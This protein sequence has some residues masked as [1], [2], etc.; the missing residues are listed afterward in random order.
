MQRM[1]EAGLQL[2]ER[3]LQRF[4]DRTP[5]LIFAQQAG[6]IIYTNAAFVRAMRGGDAKS[7]IGRQVTS[8]IAIPDRERV[9]AQLREPDPEITRAPS[10]VRCLRDDGTECILEYSAMRAGDPLQ[11][12]SIITSRDVTHAR[13]LAAEL[14]RAD[15]GFRSLFHDAPIGIAQID[16]D[17]RYQQVNRSFCELTGY[18]AD[19]LRTISYF[20]LVVPEDRAL[21]MAAVQGLQEGKRKVKL[22]KRWRR[23]DGQVIHVSMHV[24]VMT[25][26]AGATIGYLTHAADVTAELKGQEKLRLAEEQFRTIFNSAAI[27]M[28]IT[29]LRGEGHGYFQRVNQ[30]MC[31]L[32]GYTQEELLAL[33]MV[34]FRDP[35]DTASDVMRLDPDTLNVGEQ[36]R[37]VKRFR[38]KD[39][40]LIEA[41]RY[42][43]VIGDSAG[44]PAA[45]V[46]Q[47]I[48]ATVRRSIE[49][50]LHESEALHRI[51]VRN[52]PNV[53]VLLFD[54][55]LRYKLVDGE[56]L[57]AGVGLSPFQLLGKTVRDVNPPEVAERVEKMYRTALVG[58]SVRWEHHRGG[59]IFDVHASPMRDDSG[60]IVGGMVLLY[61]TTEQWK[62]QQKLA[63][64]EARLASLI[65]STGDAMC[66]LD[67]EGRITIFNSKFAADMRR[68][69]NFE[70]EP[71]VRLAELLPAGPGAQTADNHARAMKG[72]TVTLEWSD[73]VGGELQHHLLTCSPIVV[74]KEITGA[75]LTAKDITA[76]RMMELQTERQKKNFE[77]LQAIS[78]VANEST[79]SDNAIAHSLAL[80]A[81]FAGW[82]LGHA[83]KV[84]KGELVSRRIWF[85]ADLSRYARF[86]TDTERMS[87][88]PGDGLAGLVFES[89]HWAWMGPLG[90]DER[91][92]RR[93]VAA[94]CGLK[95]GFAFP[96]L[97]GDDVATVLEFFAERAEE[98]AHEIV[99]LMVNV[100][101]QLGRV[102]ERELHASE[103]RALSLTDELTGLQNRRGFLAF[104]HHAVRASARLKR[105][106]AVIFADLDGLKKINDTL[107]HEAG[108][109]A[110]IGFAK[111]LRETFREGDILSRFGGDEFVVMMQSPESAGAAAIARLNANLEKRNA[112][113]PELP[114]L[115]ASFGFVEL[116]PDG[117]ESLESLVSRA[118]A[119]MYETKKARNA[120]RAQQAAGP[121]PTP[122]S[123]RGKLRLA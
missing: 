78:A 75:V 88:R 68:T 60:A 73:T 114:A 91:F 123:P 108:D 119:L 52:L 117:T 71:G 94:L 29:V 12:I 33:P 43:S 79:T 122:A 92:E 63:D 49:K 25:D 27:G 35:L 46:I 113:N 81:E 62:L 105:T 103:V 85:E 51:L 6:R 20:E 112:S 120:A 9:A 102:I 116:N 121:A 23:K 16:L 110:I 86:R 98:P 38:S 39:G 65:E 56:Q 74:G 7:F 96:V 50:A 107:G 1:S 48:D 55:E 57:L 77:L 76:R 40:M 30:A 22:R 45:V 19:E 53:A 61:D 104:G 34:T 69:F 95:G 84:V 54:H 64:S 42:L 11:P 101:I 109:E 15:A 31:D 17:G 59:H 58:E 118:D 100:G 99:E 26:P 82:Q 8:L 47:L 32:F 111:V 67:P 36:Q 4:F 41:E 115:A 80:V 13:A 3:D 2:H 37:T 72:E 5:D 10:D 89:K 18:S 97:V 93:E 83:F 14:D 66:S 28:G 70:V 44:K 21:D 24:T 106:T 87:F 90:A